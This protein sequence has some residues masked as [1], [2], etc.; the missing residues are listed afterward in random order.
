MMIW[1]ELGVS[2]GT[3]IIVLI[4][5]YFVI[6]HAVKNGI[7]QACKEIEENKKVDSTENSHSDMN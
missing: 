7:K 1:E 3:A 6:K 2:G 5:S 4:A